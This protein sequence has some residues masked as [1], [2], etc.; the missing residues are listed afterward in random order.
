[1]SPPAGQTIEL[2]TV[3]PPERSLAVGIYTYTNAALIEAL[4]AHDLELQVR[5]A[6]AA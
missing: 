3:T 4:T 1:M 6:E 5:I 2:V